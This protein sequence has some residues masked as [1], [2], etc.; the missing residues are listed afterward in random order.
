MA[1]LE[2]ILGVGSKKAASVLTDFV[3]G[4]SEK[5]WDRGQARRAAE[6]YIE[7]YAN[8]HGQIKILGMPQPVPLSSIYT[9]VRL[10][11][12]RMP[13]A[14]K[15][16]LQDFYLN[17]GSRGFHFYYQSPIF[18]GLKLAK[19][20]RFLSILGGP[21]AGKSTLLRRIGLEQFK[22]HSVGQDALLPIFIELKNYVDANFD[23]EII[24]QNELSISGFPDS[25]VQHALKKGKCLILLDGLDEV[26]KSIINTII[27]NIEAFVDKHS[28]RKDK[29]SPDDGNRFIVS[30][31]TA[32]Y[33]AKFKRFTDVILLEFDDNQIENFINNW[34]GTSKDLESGVAKKLWKLLTFPENK[35]KL[36]LARTPLLL[37]FLCLVYG[38][39]KMLAPNRS[40]LYRRALE[41]LLDE[42][43]AEKSVERDEIYE[44]LHPDLELLMLQKIAGASFLESHFFLDRDQITHQISDF[45]QSTLNAPKSINA[46]KILEAIEVQQGLLVERSHDVYSFSH[47]TIQEY[48]AARYFHETNQLFT[49]AKNNIFNVAWREVFLLQSEMSNISQLMYGMI[50]G[51][52]SFLKEKEKLLKLVSW[53]ETCHYKTEDNI[54]SAAKRL[55]ATCFVPALNLGFKKK[56]AINLGLNLAKDLN[57][58]VDIDQNR[59]RAFTHSRTRAAAQ[60][61]FLLETVKK[62]KIFNIDLEKIIEELQQLDKRA[63]SDHETYEEKIKYCNLVKKV[64]FSSLGIN[65]D[66]GDWSDNEA[67]DLLNYL[68]A[69]SLIL[70]CKS[71]SLNFSENDWRAVADHFII[72]PKSILPIENIGDAERH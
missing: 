71:A 31:R 52:F 43:Y 7:N 5:I 29:N 42:W 19:E 69:H 16:E 35:A 41:I 59:I 18:D 51:I 65:Y 68:N 10:I 64:M 62:S 27:R 13:F 67:E 45:L 53:A 54:E 3:F 21:G 55:I 32:A 36:E 49:V 61:V 72:S 40:Y 15:T 23:L 30:C 4:I 48:L 63:P 17:R 26:S 8:R 20:V 47:L 9:S 25:F 22:S 44:G 58:N 14:T 50:S 37:T 60:A 57:V 38:R 66:L 24:L 39:I 6:N 12:Y 11:D 34:F 70:E 28:G 33:K 2:T 1:I 56:E 46:R